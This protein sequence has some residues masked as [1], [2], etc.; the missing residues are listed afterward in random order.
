MLPKRLASAVSDKLGLTGPVAGLSP[1]ARLELAKKL[2]AFP[3]TPAKA[4]GFAKAEVTIGG[5]AT[6]SVS[7]KTMEVGSVPGLYVVGE[8]L[9]V[10]G[11][12]GGYNL[13]WAYA[14]GFAAG[15]Y[16]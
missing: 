12:L 16:A 4:E 1:K 8:L 2:A 13:H 14:S 5:V 9:D 10:T 6:A 7:S 11:R 3:F 15:A